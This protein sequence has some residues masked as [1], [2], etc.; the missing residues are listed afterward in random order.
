MGQH[1]S[2]TRLSSQGK[3]DGL[4]I[5]NAKCQWRHSPGTME[6]TQQL[7]PFKMVQVVPGCGEVEGG[8]RG[9]ERHGRR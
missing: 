2:W 7:L 6:S 4:L 3:T 1:S 9:E 5:K 8:T